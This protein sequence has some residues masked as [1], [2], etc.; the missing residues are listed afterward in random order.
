MVLPCS[1][2][3]PEA[4]EFHCGGVIACVSLVEG[5]HIKVPEELSPRCRSK[6]LVLGFTLP[7][8]DELV[9]V[10]MG[11]TRTALVLLSLTSAAFPDTG[12]LHI[13]VCPKGNKL[14]CLVFMSCSE[15]AGNNPG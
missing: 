11:H 8:D 4:R 14:M 13:N 5:M 1:W 6:V 10:D 12:I 15:K 3:E 7:G 2:P 9:L